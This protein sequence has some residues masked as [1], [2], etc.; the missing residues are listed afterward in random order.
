M[1]PQVAAA[2]RPA[3]KRNRKR[4]RRVASS[5]SSSSADESSSDASA[6]LVQKPKTLQKPPP[7]DSSEDESSSSASASSSEDEFDPEKEVNAKSISPDHGVSEPSA[8]KQ[9]RDSPSPPPPAAVAIP[10]FASSSSEDEQV[11]KEK[12]RKFWMASLAE[13]FKDDLE[14]LRKASKRRNVEYGCLNISDQEP[15]L[16]PSRLA[17]LVESLAAGADVFGQTDKSVNEMEVVVNELSK[18][19]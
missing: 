8:K 5:S 7:P 18:V 12:F 2:G 11:L 1:P 17:L 6:P 14:E 16:G 15:N 3:K 4:K 13:G 19:T 10:P 9:E